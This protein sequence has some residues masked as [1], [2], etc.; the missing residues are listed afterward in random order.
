MTSQ[1]TA[2]HRHAAHRAA[3]RYR[4]HRPDQRSQG[5]PDQFHDRRLQFAYLDG[6]IGAFINAVET[7]GDTN[8][9]ATP[10]LLCLNK[11]RAEILIGAQYGYVNSTVTQTFTTQSVQFLEVGAALRFG[12]SSAR[13][14]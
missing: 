9:I 6:N 4:R 2:R 12:R 8:V 13:M 11:Q 10:K 5:W 1:R 7:I 14:A 3:Q